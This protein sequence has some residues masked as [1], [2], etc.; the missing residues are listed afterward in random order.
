VRS[1]LRLLTAALALAGVIVIA[2]L[3]GPRW[4]SEKPCNPESL[5]GLIVNIS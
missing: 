5:S 1:V 3:R 4:A 2:M